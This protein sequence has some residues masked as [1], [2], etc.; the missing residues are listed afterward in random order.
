MWEDKER[1]SALELQL[2]M[3]TDFLS[4]VIV[5]RDNITSEQFENQLN[6]LLSRKTDKIKCPS[7][8]M[9]TNEE[10]FSESL[11]LIHDKNIQRF[12][13]DWTGITRY[14][15][16]ITLSSF[17]NDK[18]IWCNMTAINRRRHQTSKKSYVMLGIAHGSPYSWSRIPS[19]F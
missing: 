3:N 7:I 4:D 10:R 13:V 8:S 9:K 19:R 6:D 15:N 12:N 11:E 14:Q 18:K 2:K 17:L 5:D 16:W 1:E